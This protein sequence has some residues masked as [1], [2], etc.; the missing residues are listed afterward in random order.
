MLTGQFQPGQ[1]YG[2]DLSCPWS[3]GMT[4]HHDLVRVEQGDQVVSGQEEGWK[5]VD[6]VLLG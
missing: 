3:Q 4:V 1:E 6:Q 2:P 5:V